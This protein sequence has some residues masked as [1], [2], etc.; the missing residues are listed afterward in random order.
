MRAARIASGTTLA[1]SLCWPALARGASDYA[2]GA[3][4]YPPCTREPSDTDV[5]AAKAAFQAGNVAFGEADYPRAILYWRDAYRRDCTA[6]ALLL[7][8]AR[9][10]ELNGNKRAAVA[11]L[12]TYLARVPTSPERAQIER[13]IAVLERQIEEQEDEAGESVSLSE[14]P[15]ASTPAPPPI[16]T[17]SSFEIEAPSRSGS[18][19]TFPLVLASTGVGIALAGGGLWIYKALALNAY[20]C[21]RSA[22]SDEVPCRD[23]KSAGKAEVT[24]RDYNI[25]GAVALGGVAVAATGIVWYLLSS[26]SE[27]APH[28]A[29]RTAL[30][31]VLGPS[32][33]G[34]GYTQRF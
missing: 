19:P 22:S 32:T 20:P 18:R 4:D 9:A 12:E 5:T 17:S 30:L 33:V 24:S 23:E 29:P 1:L 13:R 8:L 15:E 3:P 26:P 27:V 28:G 10:E 11:A 6:H 34:L 31:P 21:D 7:N 25:T 2:R 14:A 16:A